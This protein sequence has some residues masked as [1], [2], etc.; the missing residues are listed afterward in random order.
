MQML[1]LRHSSILPQCLLKISGET[2]H[3]PR[4]SPHRMF[5]R[6]AFIREHRQEL[7]RQ[8]RYLC[9][10]LAHSIPYSPFPTACLAFPL[11]W[12]SRCTLFKC[13]SATCVYTCVV[14]ISACPSKVCTLRKSAPCSP[15]CVAQLCRSICGLPPPVAPRT[16]S[17]T[18]CRVNALPRTLRNIA[19]CKVLPARTNPDRPRVKYF[20][21]ASTAD[22]PSG[23]IRS[24]SPFPLTCARA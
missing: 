23:T 7:F 17:Q 10:G 13:P 6:P 15:I 9:P 18:H 14:A 20:S 8:S 3:L 24:F 2:T 4:I 12:C 21:N 19:R 16:S 5:R 1:H 11:G 22:R